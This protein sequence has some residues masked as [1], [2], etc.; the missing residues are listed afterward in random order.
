LY[1]IV[2]ASIISYEANT[3][4]V[5]KDAIAPPLKTIS[6][7]PS[8]HFPSNFLSREVE[9]LQQKN[10]SIGTIKHIFMN[11]FMFNSTEQLLQLMVSIIPIDQFVSLYLKYIDF[12]IFSKTHFFVSTNTTFLYPHHIKL[13]IAYKVKQQPNLRSGALHFSVG[14][15]KSVVGSLWVFKKGKKELW[16]L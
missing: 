4:L 1:R 15:F 12:L 7:D 2:C 13:L 3:W 11:N 14:D 10:I 5:L 9:W 16:P 6:F 8:R